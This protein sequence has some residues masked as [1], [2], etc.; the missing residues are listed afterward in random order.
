MIIVEHVL[1]QHLVAARDD[2]RHDPEAEQQQ[3]CGMGL[4]NWRFDAEIY[5][6]INSSSGAVHTSG[7]FSYI[8]P[9]IQLFLLYGNVDTVLHKREEHVTE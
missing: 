2:E 8:R 1:P 4:R 5:C 6:F 7:H 9:S 3:K